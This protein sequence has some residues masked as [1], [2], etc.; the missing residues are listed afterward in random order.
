MGCCESSLTMGLGG[1]ESSHD[2]PLVPAAKKAHPP[3]PLVA[4][5]SEAAFNGNVREMKLLLQRGALVTQE[6][7]RHRT[8]LHFAAFNHQV[9]ACR[10]LIEQRANVNAASNSNGFSPLF[11]ACEMD[12]L[13]V[14]QVLVEA[15]ADLAMQSN[16][17][18]SPYQHAL[19]H[20]R[21]KTAAYLQQA[22]DRA[23]LG[24]GPDGSIKVA[25]VAVDVDKG[26]PKGAGEESSQGSGG[27]SVN[28]AGDGTPV[29]RRGMRRM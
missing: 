2:T 13:D 24:Q 15:N 5:M 29:G 12:D 7:R 17:G 19:R 16:E 8:P 26:A 23:A 20:N 10:W 25:D 4:R 18:H 1:P 11:A 6:D 9:D 28:P 27:N 22:M 3:D 14:V 21:V